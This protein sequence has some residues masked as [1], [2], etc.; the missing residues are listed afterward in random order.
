MFTF[1]TVSYNQENF[2]IE[3][4]ESIK[5]QIEKYAHGR[6]IHFILSDDGSKDRTILFA[7]KWLENNPG[8][9]KQVRILESSENK[10]IVFNYLRGINA[11]VTEK[12]KCTAADDIYFVNNVIDAVEDCDIMLSPVIRFTNRGDILNREDTIYY[13]FINK[14]GD[15]LLREIRTKFKYFYP[16]STVGTFVKSDIVHI[17]ELQCFMR[18][19][20]WIEDYPQW[21]YIFNKLDKNISVEIK[22]NFYVMY[23]L[24]VGIT[25]SNSKQKQVF[26]DEE[27]EM[28]QLFNARLY[29]YKKYINPYR[30]L[31]FIRWRYTKYIKKR[32]NVKARQMEQNYKDARVTAKEHLFYIRN[33]A[34]A[35][36]QEIKK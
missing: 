26:A 21:Y 7:R 24:G 29:K 30:Y 6:E 19:F 31:F 25:S 15:A 33:R 3:H 11:V 5:Y 10:G 8:L 1:L 28:K 16:I 20:K 4:L 36:Y 13:D 23:R 2:I 32:L 9:F 14:E 17:R 27:N 12:F 35:F 34:D 22:P 18:N